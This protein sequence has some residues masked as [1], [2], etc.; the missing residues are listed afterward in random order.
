MHLPFPWA[1]CPPFDSC[2]HESFKKNICIIIII[3]IQKKLILTHISVVDVVVFVVCAVY[4]LI[5]VVRLSLHFALLLLWLLLLLLL[6]GLTPFLVIF[7]V[8]FNKLSFLLC[9]FIWR[10]TQ[11]VII[12]PQRS[13]SALSLCNCRKISLHRQLPT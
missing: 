11:K 3:N 13:I 9:H 2:T 5:F 8:Y 10:G 4:H 7:C 12:T 1:H 6:F